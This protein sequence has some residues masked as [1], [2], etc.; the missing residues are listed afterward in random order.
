MRKRECIAMLLAGGQGSRLG[1]LTANLAKPAVAFGGK[2][3]LIDFTLSNCFYSNIDVVGVL[4]Q[5][6]PLMLNTYIGTG[7]AWALDSSDG[8]VVILPPYMSREGGKWYNGTADAVYQNI[9]FIDYY[10][11]DYVLVLSGDHIYKMDY[12]LMLDFHKRQHADVTLS[13]IE[14]PWE[15]ASRFGI[16]VTDEDNKVYRFDEKPKNPVSNLASMGIYIFDWQVLRAAL[17][18]DHEDPDSSNDFGGNI[19][20]KMLAEGKR[21][22]AYAFKGYWKDVGTISSYYQANMEL[23]DKNC[24]IQLDDRKFPVYS[25]SARSMPQYIGPDAHVSEALVCDGC[26]VLGE[27]HHSLLSNDVVVGRGA[28]VI[29]SIVLP[30][31]HIE[32]GA[33]VYDAIIDEGVVVERNRVVGDAHGTKGISV[34]SNATPQ[35]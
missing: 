1:G 2:Y 25:N 13:V 12:S 16:T 35:V 24:P 18:E 26:K 32:D 4:T 31:A 30:N 11:P 22:Y 33:E 34:L 3:K 20:P 7:S 15:E 5:Y 6:R 8:G 28:R 17:I 29:N 10:N 23:L 19:L 21:V 27:V 9:E 14:V